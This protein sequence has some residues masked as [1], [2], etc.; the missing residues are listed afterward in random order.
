[1]DP[2]TSDF[3][4]LWAVPKKRVP[5][6]KRIRRKFRP[7]QHAIYKLKNTIRTDHKT[8]EWFELGKLPLKTY[9]TIM[10][11]TEA[12]KAK[13]TQA[14]HNQVRDKEFVVK[15]NEEDHEVKGEKEVMVVEMEKERPNFFSRN[16]LQ[17]STQPNLDPNTT[18]VR[19]SKLA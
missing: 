8:G 10:A 9:E 5:V 18:T 14:F 17:K 13:M 6:E 7:P 15:Y 11:E 12:I 3:G 2:L 1:M 4:I 19:P 16:L